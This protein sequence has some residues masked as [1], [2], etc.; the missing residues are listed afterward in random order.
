MSVSIDI[1]ILV[2][3]ST[4]ATKPPAIEQPVGIDV[5]YQGQYPLSYVCYVY[6]MQRG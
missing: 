1:R 6:P 2:L 4:D 3:L 5:T